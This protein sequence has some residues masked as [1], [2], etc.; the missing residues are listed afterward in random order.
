MKRSGLA[1]TIAVS[2]G[3]L[4]SE[5]VPRLNRGFLPDGSGGKQVHDRGLSEDRMHELRTP[6][7]LA[8]PK[9]F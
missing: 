2:V 7:M 9:I 4:I 5:G 3:R 6:K 8:C 1:F